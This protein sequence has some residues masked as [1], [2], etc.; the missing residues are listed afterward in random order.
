MSNAN[1]IDYGFYRKP[2]AGNFLAAKAEFNLDM[3]K[4]IMVGDWWSNIV[5]ANAAEVWDIYLLIAKNHNQEKN[6][7]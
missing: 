6:A 3:A 7:R 4:S 2:F 5:V 1:F